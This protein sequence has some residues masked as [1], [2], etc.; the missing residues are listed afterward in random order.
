[1]TVTVSLLDD[2]VGLRLTGS[3]DYASANALERD[4]LALL[5][6]LP[7]PGAVPG[8]MPGHWL[9]DLSGLLT[10]SS[11]TAAVLMSWQRAAGARQQRLVLRAIP[12]RLH[13][14]LKASNLLDVFTLAASA[15][16]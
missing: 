6:S 4:G 9:C 10:G 14:I 16:I 11:V 7:L 8:G 2:A 12:D 15:P 1:M 5:A 13:A 3:V